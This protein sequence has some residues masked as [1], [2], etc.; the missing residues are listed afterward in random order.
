MRCFDSLVFDRRACSK[1]RSRYRPCFGSRPRGRN[2]IYE[3]FENRLH[4]YQSCSNKRTNE[5]S[6][7][8]PF[9]RPL[10]ATSKSEVF[11]PGNDRATETVTA[12]TR[13]EKKK[14]KEKKRERKKEK[15]F[16]PSKRLDQRTAE[17]RA[18]QSINAREE[19]NNC[20]A[21]T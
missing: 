14:R 10:H 9:A 15:P 20:S 18:T 16:L 21:Q 17:K 13:E 1:L 6:L 7:E 19:E 5:N 4:H 8:I 2:P 3:I 11:G 12:S